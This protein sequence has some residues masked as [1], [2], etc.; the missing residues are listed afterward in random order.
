MKKTKSKSKHKLRY[1]CP[2]CG[3]VM[4]RNMIDGVLQEHC[5]NDSIPQHAKY[6][7]EFYQLDERKKLDEMS[8]WT[9]QRHELFGA[10][11]LSTKSPKDPFVCTYKVDPKGY[12]IPI[13]S[14]K[15]LIPD[16]VQVAISEK[17]LK[18]KLTENE[19]Y[20]ETPRKYVEPDGTVTYLIDR[21]PVPLLTEAGLNT[22][23]TID[24]VMYPTDISTRYK[25]LTEVYNPDK[26]D[27]LF[28]WEKL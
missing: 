8:K 9:D 19:R 11:W 22:E 24:H 17:I 27:R 7:Q 13:G 14:A 28:D 26:M 5:S 21:H 18:R 1:K 6:F 20:G 15:V 4:H 23:D 10:W 3:S 12:S 16:P 25:D 2:E